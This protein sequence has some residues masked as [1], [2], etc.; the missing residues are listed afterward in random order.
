MEN[1]FMLLLVDYFD[2]ITFSLPLQC[3][4]FLILL[5][6]RNY[7][8]PRS[9]MQKIPKWEINEYYH[10][11]FLYSK[12]HFRQKYKENFLYEEKNHN[13]N[14]TKERRR[15]VKRNFSHIRSLLITFMILT[16][17]TPVTVSATPCAVST[18]SHIG[19]SVITSNES[20]WTSVT[21]HQA[22]AHPPTIVRFLVD[23]Q[24]PPRKES[25]YFSINFNLH[26]ICEGTHRR[27]RE[28]MMI[29]SVKRRS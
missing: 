7:L 23:P 17:A 24:H 3:W 6:R 19:L 14:I 21:S 13:P 12:N 22:Q 4:D 18:I 2:F 1:V 5:Y 27:E 11:V 10:E 25:R 9:N 15:K 29:N 20:F 26:T 28:W 8:L 16:W